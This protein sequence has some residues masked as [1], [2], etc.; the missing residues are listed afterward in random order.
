MNNKIAELDKLFLEVGTYRKSEEFNELL[1]FIKKFPK[2]A[3]FNAMLIHVQKPGSHYVATATEWQ[4]KFNRTIK[5]GSRPLITLIPF[6]PV[7]FVFELGDTEGKV[8]FPEKLT[9]PFKVDGNLSNTEFERLKSNLLCDGINYVEKEYGAS[10]AGF[11]QSSNKARNAIIKKSKKDIKVSILY[12]MVIN[13]THE[14]EDRFATILHELG[15]IYCGH[16]GTPYDKWWKDRSGLS[17]N[18]REFEAE[19][20]CWLV[21]ERTGLK[22]PSAEYLSGYLDNN[23]EIPN[24][25]VDVI[26]RAV[27]IIESML[28]QAKNPRKEIIIE[29]IEKI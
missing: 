20:V 9:K 24:V 7:S 15:H 3:P 1:K 11:V 22:N 23:K 28:K 12:D 13:S 14:K 17:K 18:E 19:S 16:L 5:P 10:S 21:C 27:G 4:T 25:S 26:L 2:T 29:V 6:G 8:E